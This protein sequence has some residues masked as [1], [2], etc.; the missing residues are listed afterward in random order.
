MVILKSKNKFTAVRRRNDAGF[1]LVESLVAVV[2]VSI[3][4]VGST[5]LVVTCFHSNA[6]TRTFA[7]VESDINSIID[8]YRNAAYSTILAKFGGSP[9]SIADGQMAVEA[10]S[11]STSRTTYSTQFIAIRSAAG[12]QPEAVRLNVT[13]TQRRGGG[14]GNATYTFETIIAQVQ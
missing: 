1:A 14:M 7:G 8:G 6:A 3:T 5:S 11:V 13:A 4:V 2:L 12:N 10:S 9:G